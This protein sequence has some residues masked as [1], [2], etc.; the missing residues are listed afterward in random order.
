MSRENI[1]QELRKSGAR[2][3]TIPDVYEVEESRVEG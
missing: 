2:W 3:R 1:V